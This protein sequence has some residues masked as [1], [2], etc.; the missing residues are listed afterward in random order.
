MILTKPQ[1]ATL[2]RD[3]FRHG[4]IEST[5]GCR[6]Y[7][8][9]DTES[10]RADGQLEFLGRIDH[11]IKLRGIRIELGEIEAALAR[12]E[13]VT[14][15]VVILHEQGGHKRLA[16]YVVL[17]ASAVMDTPA[18]ILRVWLKSM[19]PNYMIPASFTVLDRLP[20]TPSGKIDRAALHAPTPAET[21]RRAGLEYEAPRTEAERRL[22]A[23]W[24]EVLGVERIGRHDHFFDMGGH[25]LLATQLVARI[26]R[27]FHCRLSL[28]V[29]FDTS[30]L[31]ALA[32][33]IE[34]FQ[35]LRGGANDEQRVEIEL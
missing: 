35:W 13:A 2:N 15:A 6:L 9:G 34:T 4:I 20:L 25:S 28:R 32:A 10:L 26:E 7:H 31:A 29:V 1:V 12:Q 17:D 11:Q 22:A 16:A 33:Y 18:E 27:A 5:G 8:T 30:T 3:E 14:N 19:L 21:D 24:T 23:I